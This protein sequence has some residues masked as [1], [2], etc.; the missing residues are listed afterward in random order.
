MLYSAFQWISD[1]LPGTPVFIRFLAFPG[2]KVNS[3]PPDMS[4]QTAADR[5]VHST[6]G[7]ANHFL[8]LPPGLPAIRCFTT[9]QS[10]QRPIKESKQ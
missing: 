7:I 6:L 2:T 10:T 1:L 9:D 4:L 8:A 5:Q 3:L